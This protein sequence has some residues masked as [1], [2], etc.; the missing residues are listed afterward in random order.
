[1][2]NTPTFENKVYKTPIY[3]RKA[4]SNYHNRK[5]DDP[6]Y[7]EKR[8]QYQQKYYQSKKDNNIVSLDIVKLIQ[9][10]NNNNI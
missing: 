10:I 4:I 5:K 9:N 3:T 6:E 8:K 2:N 1:M 7:K